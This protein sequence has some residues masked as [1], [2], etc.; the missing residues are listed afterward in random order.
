M[1]QRNILLSDYNDNLLSCTS[2][3]CTIII[4]MILVLTYNYYTGVCNNY[5]IY[6]KRGRGGREREGGSWGKERG[7]IIERG[8]EGE[9]EV[10]ER[11]GGRDT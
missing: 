10:R 2:C 4:V 1:T 8:R 6:T 11:G 7:I 9:R 5:G 3:Y